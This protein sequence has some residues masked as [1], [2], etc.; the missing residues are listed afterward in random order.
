M[1]F[2]SPLTTAFIQILDCSP[3]ITSPMTCAEG[4]I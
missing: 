4:S 2:T 1:E 3:R